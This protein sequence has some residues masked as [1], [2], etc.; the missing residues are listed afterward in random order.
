MHCSSASRTPLVFSRPAWWI[1]CFRSCRLIPPIRFL[2]RLCTVRGTTPIPV[3]CLGGFGLFFRS[4][5]VCAPTCRP[6]PSIHSTGFIPARLPSFLGLGS[7]ALIRL[8]RLQGHRPSAVE[9]SVRIY[10]RDDIGPMLKLQADII[11]K[12]RSG[13]RPL[14]PVARGS[15]NP[16]PD[17][18]VCLPPP[19]VPCLAFLPGRLLP[20][21][22]CCLLPLWMPTGLLTSIKVGPCS[23]V[24]SCRTVKFAWSCMPAAILTSVFRPLLLP[25]CPA[26]G[27]AVVAPMLLLPA[28]RPRLLTGPAR[29]GPDSAGRRDG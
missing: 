9:G 11:N 20:R 8:R 5:G 25:P 6:P 24:L 3:P 22:G 15:S 2:W 19:T 27:T 4:T 13:H 21:P 23:G 29:P 10:S 14:Q 17:F 18:R 26:V 16:L 1:S 12:I 28:L 7:S